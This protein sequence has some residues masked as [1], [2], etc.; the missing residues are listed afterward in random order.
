[1]TTV[2]PGAGTRRPG[3]AAAGPS[4]EP[5]YVRLR[6]AAGDAATIT[7]RYLIHLRS[8]P[9]RAVMALALPL[10]FTLLFVYVLGSNMAVPDG[11]SYVDFLIPGM[12]AQITV[13]GVA[14]SAS[15][16]ADDKD[17]G[18]TDRFHSLP[19]SRIGVPLGQSLA[20]ILGGLLTLLVMAGCGLL[21]GWRPEASGPRLAAAFALLVFARYAF[22]WLGMWLGLVLP[23]RSAT[24]LIGML[25][26]PLTMVSNVFVPTDGLPAGVR[27]VAEWNPVSAVVS[28]VRELFGHPVPVA[29]GAGWPLAHPVAAALGWSLLLLAVFGP[30]AVSA[31]RTPKH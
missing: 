14:A 9:E 30:L 25:T 8:A 12:L 24:D 13:F 15:A 1:M 6:W 11:G 17:K 21:V 4:R 27:P 7:R 16:V 26:F 22:G 2:R 29:D 18:I 20:E 10:V 28:A 19:M 31:F 3:G 5:L 23:S